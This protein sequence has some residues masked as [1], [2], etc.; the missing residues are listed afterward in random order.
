MS[1]AFLN[2]LQRIARKYAFKCCVVKHIITGEF[3]AG[4]YPVLGQNDNVVISW[5]NQ[6]QCFSSKEELEIN[7]QLRFPECSVSADKRQVL[8]YCIECYEIK[9]IAEHVLKEHVQKC[10]PLI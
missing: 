10:M 4:I 9:G 3:F 8:P 6:C 5:N 7:L 2:H 1:N